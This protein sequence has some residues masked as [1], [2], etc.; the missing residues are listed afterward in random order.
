LELLGVQTI[1]DDSDREQ[2]ELMA[3]ELA[4]DYDCSSRGFG[5]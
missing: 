2:I 1:G 4:G 3:E 5:R